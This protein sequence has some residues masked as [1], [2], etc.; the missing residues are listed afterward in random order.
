MADLPERVRQEIKEWADT[1]SPA[2]ARR[3][4]RQILECI[5]HLAAEEAARICH[6]YAEDQR[7][8][9]LAGRGAGDCAD[10]I[11]RAFGLKKAK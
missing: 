11:R 5:A 4:L 6:K 2:S 7:I 8:H 1:V 3:E 10:A 9:R